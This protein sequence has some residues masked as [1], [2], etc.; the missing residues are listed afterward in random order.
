MANYDL[1]ERVSLPVFLSPWD[2]NGSAFSFSTIPFRTINV[3]VYEYTGQTSNFDINEIPDNNYIIDSLISI[4]DISG[5][6]PGLLIANNLSTLELNSYNIYGTIVSAYRF[7]GIPHLSWAVPSASQGSINPNYSEQGVVIKTTSG[8]YYYIQVTNGEVTA[9]TGTEISSPIT[10][11]VNYT[12]EVEESD[13]PPDSIY[14]EPARSYVQQGDVIQFTAYADGEVY[15]NVEWSM[16]ET[17][18]MQ[19]ETDLNGVTIDQTGKMTVNELTMSDWWV[20]AKFTQWGI[21]ISA[22]V[23]NKND[24]YFP[25]TP[26][27]PGFTPGTGNPGGGPSGPGTG[28]LVPNGSNNPNVA[29][30]GTFTMYAANMGTLQG[31]GA[32]LY[33]NNF[34]DAVG[35]DIMNSLWN[36]PIEGIISITAFPFGVPASANVPENIKF[37]NLEVPI[38]LPVLQNSSYQIN[39]GSVSI[40]PTWNSFL[41]YAP[42]TK[43]ELY[44]PFSTGFV[45]LDPSDVMGGTVSVVTNIDLIKGTCVHIVSSKYG[46]IGTYG[47]VCGLQIPV[48]GV[49][50]AGKALNLLV[51]GV[52]TAVSAGAGAFAGGTHVAA[53]ITE[54]NT[55]NR[56]LSGLRTPLDM[57]MQEARDMAGRVGAAAAQPLLD[58]SRRYNSI[59]SRTAGVAGQTALAAFRT[60]ASIQRSGSFATNGGGLGPTTPF[61]IFSCPD[62]NIPANYGHF[63]GYPLNATMRIGDLKGYSE[64]TGVHL[65]NVPALVPELDEISSL[66]EGGVIL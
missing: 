43:I 60:P 63:Y 55:T 4:Y 13:S 50:T 42:H 33:S 46:V 16:H 8:N 31:L 57:S 27:G 48:S 18:S 32:W 17:D 56:V 44:L 15:S 66:L 49:D 45:T 26:S 24:P 29:S 52:T 12:G 61:I 21:S 25:T 36:S 5:V 2:T 38:S 1:V 64:I 53:G 28:T 7:N 59:A 6:E 20:K 11:L 54:T 51:S 19:E 14:I 47:G 3:P 40:E 10:S 9:L 30:G 22:R 23:V 34:F 39:W 37:G 65:N 58:A 41:D 62:V 35:R